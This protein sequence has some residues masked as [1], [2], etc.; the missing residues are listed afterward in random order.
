MHSLVG[1]LKRRC[2][3]E[4]RRTSQEQNHPMWLS[5]NG[6]QAFK[7]AK[8]QHFENTSQ[9]RRNGYFTVVK[10]DSISCAVVL[11]L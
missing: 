2:D 4:E 3:K 1:H 5:D 10:K 7:C 8:R 6:K 9:K 11:N